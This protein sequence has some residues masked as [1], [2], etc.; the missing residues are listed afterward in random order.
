MDKYQFGY[1]EPY[2]A[3]F[4]Q[5]LF[6]QEQRGLRATNKVRCERTRYLDMVGAAVEVRFKVV[7]HI[8]YTYAKVTPS[9]QVPSLAVFMYR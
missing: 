3:L 7:R 6:R 9:F 5:R 8:I 2:T 1:T 4:R